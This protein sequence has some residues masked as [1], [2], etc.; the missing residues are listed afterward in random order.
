MLLHQIP[1]ELF[2]LIQS[3][4]LPQSL[5]LHN[6]KL[7]FQMNSFVLILS[8]LPVLTTWLILVTLHKLIVLLI[9]M[10][11]MLKMLL[12]VAHTNKEVTH[13]NVD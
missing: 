8:S 11:L 5:L 9:L 7:L 12:L 4:I 6:P 1:Q 3:K 2:S 10:L 13:L